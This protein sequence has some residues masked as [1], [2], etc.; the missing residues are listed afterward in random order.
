MKIASFNYVLLSHVSQNVNG[1][2]KTR[3]VQMRATTD[4]AL[5]YQFCV[6]SHQADGQNGG[7]D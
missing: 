3:L 7:T 6:L 1:H 4:N 5:Y 2:D